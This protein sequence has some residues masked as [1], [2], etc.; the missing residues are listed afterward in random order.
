VL[1]SKGGKTHSIKSCPLLTT[2]TKICKS[3]GLAN[4]T[5]SQEGVSASLVNVA[6]KLESMAKEVDAWK[7]EVRSMLSVHNKWLEA[8]EKKMGLKHKAETPSESSTP[9]KKR[10]GKKAK[11]QQQSGGGNTQVQALG[12]GQQPAGK[13]KPQQT[14]LQ[15]GGNK[16]RG[17][18]QAKLTAPREGADWGASSSLLD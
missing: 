4:F 6:V 7:K 13:P 10:K 17:K 16:G 9:A 18:Q 8:L 15:Q 14:Q 3:A 5:V 12:S 11:G 1:Y 2:F